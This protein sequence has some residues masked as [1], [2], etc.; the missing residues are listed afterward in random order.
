M[1]KNTYTEPNRELLTYAR[2][3]GVALW[4]IAA[5][6]SYGIAETTLRYRLNRKKFDA[7]QKSV[8]MRTVDEINYHQRKSRE[9]AING[10]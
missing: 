9:E 3:N 5:H 6:P 1:E 8:F 2:V 4:K 10:K 7:E